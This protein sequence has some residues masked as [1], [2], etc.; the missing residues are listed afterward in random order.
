MTTETAAGSTETILLAGFSVGMFVLV[1]LA[2]LNASSERHASPRHARRRP[3]RFPARQKETDTGDAG[4][5]PLPEP[6]RRTPSQP[7]TSSPAR[8]VRTESRP[9]RRDPD[10]TITAV[11]EAVE[12]ARRVMRPVTAATLAAARAVAPLVAPRPPKPPPLSS[13]KNAWKP[14]PRVSLAPNG[15]WIDANAAP[16]GSRVSFRWFDGRQAHE[17]VIRFEPRKATGGHFVPTL[18]KPVAA[19]ILAVER[20][21]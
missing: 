11:R 10:P 9:V 19:A 13:V 14:D 2:A 18:T 17:G 8:Y 3:Y 15:F 4:A 5:P 21:D 7:A 1:G 20:T 12:E 16:E 6:V